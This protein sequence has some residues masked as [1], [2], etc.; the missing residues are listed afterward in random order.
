MAR[1][2]VVAGHDPSYRLAYGAGVDADREACA[3]LDVVAACVVSSETEQ[4]GVRVRA[5]RPREEGLWLAEAR[6]LARDPVQ[7]LKSGL[8]AR[9]RAVE[10]LAEIV[11]ELRAKHPALPVVVDPVLAASGGERFLDDEGLQVLREVLLARSVIVTPNLPEAARLTGR[12]PEALESDR[13]TRLIAA[14]DLLAL[15]ASAVVL[16]GGHAP[17]AL[18]AD[19]VLTREGDPLWLERPRIHDARVHGSGCRFAS[20]LAAGLALGRPVAE[21]ARAAGD[22]LVRMLRASSATRGDA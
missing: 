18:A 16:K 14:R 21:A 3:Q 1:V 20:A 15:G 4:D 2:L 5:V 7:A 13:R 22:Y 10:A 9:A 8:L 17:D 19:L 6:A 12:T 11:D